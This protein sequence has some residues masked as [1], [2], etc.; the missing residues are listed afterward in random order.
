MAQDLAGELKRRGLD[1]FVTI[2]DAPLTERR[3]SGFDVDFLWYDLKA[4]ALPSDADML[5]VDG[6]S[7]EVNEYARY[8][9][10]P[11]LLPKL[12]RHAHIFVNDADRHDERQLGLQWRVLYPDLG[13]REI[14]TERGAFEMYFLDDKMRQFT[15]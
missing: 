13:V 2:V 5:V 4:D 14:P 6:P 11:Q 1:S 8:P 12:A 3:Y 9:A 15:R 10:G 7:A